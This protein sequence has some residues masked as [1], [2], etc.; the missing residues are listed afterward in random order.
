MNKEMNKTKG[1]TAIQDLTQQALK[2]ANKSQKE[3]T[4]FANKVFEES[5]INGINLFIELINS[6][7]QS[8]NHITKNH[9]SFIRLCDKTTE[10]LTKIIEDGNVTEEE[11]KE[12]QKMVFE[13]LKMANEQTA[14]TREAQ[15]EGRNIAIKGSIAGTTIIGVFAVVGIFAK[16]IIDTIFKK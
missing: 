9:K 16:K 12:A 4:I 6:V 8:N 11:R 10:S 14:Q 15:R 13:V 5:S 7:K 3:Q 2:V 1:N